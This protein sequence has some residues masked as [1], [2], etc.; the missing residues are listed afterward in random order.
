MNISKE[1]FVFCIE[2]I[3][4]IYDVEDEVNRFLEKKEYIQGILTACTFPIELL[5]RTLAIALGSIEKKDEYKYIIEEI[6]WWLFEDVEKIITCND[7]DIDV[8]KAE[9]FYDY[10]CDTYK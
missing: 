4:E 9:N 2:N 10:L 1:D 8:T 3:K 6:E 5:V 7:K